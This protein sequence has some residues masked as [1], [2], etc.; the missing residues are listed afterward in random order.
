MV[1]QHTEYHLCVRHN[2]QCF[3]MDELTIKIVGTVGAEVSGTEDI[4]AA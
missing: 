1:N 4:G 3:Y 2:A